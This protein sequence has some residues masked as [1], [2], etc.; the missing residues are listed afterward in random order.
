MRKYFLL[1]LA[2]AMP[3]AFMAQEDDPVIMNVAGNDIQRSEF[4]Y[5]FNKNNT[6]GRTDS[7][8]VAEY[9]DL[10]V[11]FKLKVA[12]AIDAG[13]DTTQSFLK[14][15]AEYRGIEAE[16]YL[17]PQSRIENLA[18][19]IFNDSRRE[20]GEKGLYYLGMI[21]VK[22]EVVTRETVAEAKALVD[23]LRT[24][25]V[26]GADF[27]EIASRYSQDEVAQNGGMVG[28]V[29]E[30]QLPPVLAR[31]VFSLEVNELSQTHLSEYGCQLFKV[32]GQQKFDNFEEHRAS[33]MEW[34]E[35]KGLIEEVKLEQARVLAEQEGW[36]LTPEQALA[37]EDSLLEDMH[38][39]FKLLSREYHDGLLLFDISN[40]E[41]WEKAANDTAMLEK[42]FNDHRKSYK[43]ENPVFKGIV[44]FGR[45]EDAIQSL[46]ERLSGVPAEDWI[47]E[48]ID[49]NTDS[50]KVRVMRGPFKKGANKFCDKIVFNEG[51][52]DP[53]PGF[54][55]TGYVGNIY[56]EPETWLD[57]SGQVVGDCQ[58]EL[59]K[60]WVRELR[61]RYKYKINKKVL[62]TVGNHE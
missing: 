31:A 59:E 23:S 8:A 6:E 20:V 53:M 1:G 48:V 15:Y 43:F 7:K 37:R 25:I 52:C 54:P 44:V 10:F 11:N 62:K 45:S 41:I 26:N 28:W 38:P 2:L 58:A 55:V 32:F 35:E 3:V 30:N 18:R 33:I 14:E 12:A 19:S 39:E 27:R 4:E 49:F 60:Q 42:W 46:R 24:L 40:A 29:G 50:L 9:A 57:V 51:E 47:Q 5:F 61:G 13:L 17:A 21:T 22:P 16:K 36:D 34:I 56:T